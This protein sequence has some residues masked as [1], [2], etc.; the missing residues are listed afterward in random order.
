MFR[1]CIYIYA[2]TIYK[3]HIYKVIYKHIYI[4]PLYIYPIYIYPIYIYISNIS[5]YIYPIYIYIPY[6]IY[7]L[8]K[9]SPILWVFTFFMVFF[10]AQKFNILIFGLAI[11]YCIVCVFGIIFK[12][13]S[14][15]PGHAD[16]HL[17][18]LLIIK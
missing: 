3:C 12:K 9:F 2:R 17:C 16:L 8:Q 4:N 1:L 7:D 6:Q 18:F 14:H 10:E 15:N 13:P 5:L 11:F